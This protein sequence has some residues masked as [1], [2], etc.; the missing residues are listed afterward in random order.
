MMH[1]GGKGRRQPCHRF[2]SQP[3]VS[4]RLRVLSAA[5]SVALDNDSGTVM[6]RVGF[7]TFRFAGPGLKLRY[8]GY[9][10]ERKPPWR[11]QPS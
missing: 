8:D 11:E 10:G 7:S 9:R 1:F 4:D 5:F 3:G 2:S 6:V